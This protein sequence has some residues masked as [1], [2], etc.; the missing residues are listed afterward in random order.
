MKKKDATFN[1]TARRLLKT[2]A[3]IQARIGI[4][5]QGYVGL[6]LA[7]AFAKK[8]F[9]VSGIDVDKRKIESLRKGKSYIEDVPSREVHELVSKK[10]FFP[11]NSFD[12]LAKQDAVIICVPTPLNRVRDP[13]LS[14]ITRAA[15][16][17]RQR[18][19]RGQLIILE[20]TTY[21]GTTEEIILPNLERSGLRAGQDFFLCF[22]PER[23]DP[24]NKNFPL[25]KI[26]KVVGGINPT[27]T[28]LGA[29][30]YSNISEKVVPVSSSRTAEMAKLLENTFRIVNIGLVNE[31]AR[32]ADVLKINIWEAIDAASTKPFGFMP[33]YPGPGIGGHCVGIDPIYLSWKARLQGADVRFIEL[34]RRINEEMPRFVI[35]KAMH[36]LNT[37]TH[38][39]VSLSKI[40]IGGVS[41]KRDVSDTRESPALEI[42][43][44]LEKLGAKVNYHDP[45]VPQ[46]KSEKIHLKSLPLT[47]KNLK[48]QDLVI[49]VTDHTSLDYEFLA[50]NAPLVFD[51][52]NVKWPEKYSSRV[53]RL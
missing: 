16:S 5:G 13:D 4:I 17:I 34:A 32:V 33:F 22:S 52:R 37:R 20:S 11:T 41:Y 26:P 21:P 50:K 30:L 38:K 43:H 42:I 15:D 14:F 35:E 48:A 47:A 27:S 3:S 44:G 36:M 31:L 2:L 39:A 51:T 40:L 53:V 6:P 23:I 29:A 24:G 49:L 1:R 46:I 7:I 45:F 28:R 18:L 25:H 9:R 12:V 19:H 8:G 10:L